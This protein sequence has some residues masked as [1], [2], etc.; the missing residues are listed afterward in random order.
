M[1]GNRCGYVK[2]EPRLSLVCPVPDNL[3]KVIPEAMERCKKIAL[4]PKRFPELRGGRQLHLLHKGKRSWRI[5]GERLKRE[6][7]LESLALVMQRTMQSCDIIKNRV[8]R[9]YRDRRYVHGVGLLDYARDCAITVTRAG[10][11]LRNAV[12]LGWLTVKQGREE[13]TPKSDRPCKCC[14]AGQ[15]EGRWKKRWCAFNNVYSVTRQFIARL[16]L[17]KRWK[18]E[19][20]KK[21]KREGE[22]IRAEA[23]QNI[24]VIRF[25]REQQALAAKVATEKAAFEARAQETLTRLQL[26]EV[27]RLKRQLQLENPDW[28]PGRLELEARRRL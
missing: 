13:Y 25:H 5:R 2:G 18:K 20:E 1:T 6:E 16:G 21:Q 7:R 17:T 8:G 9:P 15:H 24:T 27:D 10:R 11:A 28:G 3:P 14:K 12:E 19:Q 23:L 22:A 4:N 26:A